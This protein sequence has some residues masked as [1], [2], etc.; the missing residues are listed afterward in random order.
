MPEDAESVVKEVFQ[1]QTTFS[2]GF[3]ELLGTPSVTVGTPIRQSGN[4]VGALLLH[5]PVKGINDAV[6]QGFEKI[7]AISVAAALGISIVLSVLLAVSFTKP[8]K[9]MK[10]STAQLAGGDYS[11]KTGVQRD[12]EIG[13]LASSIDILS[14]R[15]EQADRE[16]ENLAKLRQDFVANISHELRTPV[17]VIRG[18]LEALYDEVVTDPEQIKIYHRQMLNES[19]FLQ[20]LVDDLLDLSRLQNIDFKIEMQEIDICDVLSDVLR[21][22]R[23]IAS[24]KQIQIQFE[25]DTASCIVTGDYGRIRQMLMI[26]LDNAVKF[27]PEGGIVSMSLVNREVVI[28]DYGAGISKKDLPYIFERF[29]KS[30]SEQNKNGTGLGLAIAKQIAQRHHISLSVS[31]STSDGTAFRMQF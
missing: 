1:G 19:I 26:I 22:A 25:K 14:E 11:A 4:I 16:S 17:T 23:N 18:S 30:K 5:S 12:D 6:G 3:S 13:E 21:S 10:N 20:R 9:M 27:S 2:K 15:L 31:S 28:R 24:G 7:L 8:L 29:Y